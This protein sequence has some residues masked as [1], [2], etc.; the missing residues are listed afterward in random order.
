MH[1]C[2]FTLETEYKSAVSLQRLGVKIRFCEKSEIGPISSGE[3]TSQQNLEITN[4]ENDHRD[5]KTL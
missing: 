1:I 2:S 5:H 4:D 3:E